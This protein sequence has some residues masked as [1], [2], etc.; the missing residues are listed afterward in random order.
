MGGLHV[1]FEILDAQGR[2]AALAH[3][4]GHGYRPP[5][6]MC[7][8][9]LYTV[10]F[11]PSE[12]AKTHANPGW[13]IFIQD[14]NGTAQLVHLEKAAPRKLVKFKEGGSMEQCDALY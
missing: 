8:G 7:R 10:E 12:A 13:C 1:G 4:G 5:S 2:V 6:P 11:T 9:D 14:F 3:H